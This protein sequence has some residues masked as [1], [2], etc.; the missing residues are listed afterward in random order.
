MCR[1]DTKLTN[2]LATPIVAGI[3]L[4]CETVLCGSALAQVAV[5]S[6]ATSSATVWRRLGNESV[7]LGLAGPVTGPVDSVWFSAAG[8]HLYARTSSGRVFETSD[9]TTWIPSKTTSSP[10]AEI[11][12]SVTVQSS[13]PD[14]K[15]VLIA[16]RY[17][18]LGRNLEVSDDEGRS[19]INLTAYN[20]DSVIGSNQRSLATS[21]LDP[22]VLVVANDFGV[23]RSADGGLSWSS[24]NEALPNLPIRR[25]LPPSG[26]GVLRGEIEGIGQVELPPAAAA[27][28][29]NWVR[30]PDVREANE[31]LRRTAGQALGTE[32]TAL[33]RTATTWFAGS[34]DGR[35]WNSFDNGA[36]W[37]ILPQRAA[38]RIESI[39]TGGEMPGDM[40]H[41]AL[42]V[43]GSRI[44]R[45]VNDGA[46]WEDIAANLSDSASQDRVWHGIAMDGAAGV[47]YI[48]GD[49]GVFTA[50]VDM[51]NLVPVT[52]WERIS[53]LPDARAMDVRLDR[54][55]NQLYVAIDGYGAYVAPAPHKSGATRL[56]NAADQPAQSMAPGV[57]LRVEA[58]GLAAVKAESGDFALVA[59]SQSS[60]QVQVPFEASGSTLAFTVESSQGQ[61]R[62]ALPLKSAAPSILVDSD[63]LPILVDASTGL[64][65]D[66]RNTAHPGA[67]IQVFAAGL[68]TVTP[69]WRAGVPAPEN[70]PVV[71]AQ[72]EARLNGS[73][74]EVTRATLAAGYVG[75]YL[76]E[77]QLPGLVNTGAADFV[78]QVNG[79]LSNQ[80]KIMLSIENEGLN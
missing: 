61:N 78:L 19:F 11:K 41:S 24:L 7:G 52:G 51:N 21:P 5:P 39:E 49:R 8:D 17:W 6:S 2:R 45:T 29:T 16:G 25:L 14:A 67:R 79:E 74:I 71:D 76:V 13:D 23:W 28:Q 44:L 63:G 27:A 4:L 72:V 47:A 18:S 38:G 53:G 60:A 22:R 10:P 36:T 35:F 12:P 80:V 40:P 77:V 57:L 54:V 43:A 42:A 33:A 58:N 26:S 59:S 3:A 75:L 73:P 9:F 50:R 32:I 30:S 69:R 31:Q 64:T 15:I 68:G 37:T 1:M 20:G 34:S 46:Y 65:L 62:F 66:A 55:R 70:P 48:A 56:L